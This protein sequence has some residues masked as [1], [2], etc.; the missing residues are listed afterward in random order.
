MGSKKLTA[1]KYFGEIGRAICYLFL[2]LLCQVLVST[3]YTFAAQIY[4]MLNPTHSADLME[5]ILA[6][7]DQISIVSNV[8][9]LVILTA[10]FLLRRK[11]PFCEAGFHR[12]PGRFVAAAV[13]VTPILYA[14]ISLVLGLL[15]EAWLE[16]YAEASASLNQ[17]GVL[18]SV[19]TVILAP[20]AEEI[21][22][23]GLILSRLGRVFP[24]WLA[25]VLSALLFGV[26]HGHPVW[27]AYA[28][29]LGVI[30]GFMDLRARSIWPSLA[31]HVIFNGT[32]QL[33]I[34]LPEA[35]AAADLFIG[36]L[37]VVGVALCTAVLLY[38]HFRPLNQKNGDFS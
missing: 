2:F 5:L 1:G 18:I 12:T 16:S 15:P 10:F 25:V 8:A 35:D 9:V 11:N 4:V 6:C 27:I 3:V 38:R 19:A 21:I 33:T 31:A 22:F 37:L 14:G 13:A 23:R 36:V 32:S 29:F 20:I 7:T 30:F 24:G 17:T 28:F 26:C 34:Y